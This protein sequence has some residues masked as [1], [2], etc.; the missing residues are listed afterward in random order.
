MRYIARA[1]GAGT[2]LYEGTP[3]ELAE[4]DLMMDQVS[5]GMSTSAADDVGAVAAERAVAWL[6]AAAAPLALRDVM[7]RRRLGIS[8]LGFAPDPVWCRIMPRSRLLE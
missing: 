4:I 3:A 1:Y 8:G 7:L 6:S 5:H 2:G